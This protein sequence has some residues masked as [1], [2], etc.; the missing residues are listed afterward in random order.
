MP[1]GVGAGAVQ[2]E[3][4]VVGQIDRAGAIGPGLVTDFQPVIGS[5]PVI[6]LN[7]KIAGKSLVAVG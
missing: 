2:I 4:G 1:A 5:E 6:D 3:I 7:L